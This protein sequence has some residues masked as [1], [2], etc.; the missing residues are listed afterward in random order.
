[1]KIN[2]ESPKMVAKLQNCPPRKAES[3]D[4][5]KEQLTTIHQVM[6]ANQLNL[7]LR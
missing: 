3:C 2:K 5:M 7:L 6:E 4:Q 1:M